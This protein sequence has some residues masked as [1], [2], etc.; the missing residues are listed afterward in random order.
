MTNVHIVP[1]DLE[2]WWKLRS[3]VEVT[4]IVA[5]FLSSYG[6][7]QQGSNA[8][9][10]P[11]IG[12]TIDGSIHPE[13]ISDDQAIRIWLQ[14]VSEPSTA[15]AS[16]LQRMRVKVA[17][18][19]LPPDDNAL[20]LR[21]TTHFADVMLSFRVREQELDR[22][23]TTLGYSQRQKLAADHEQLFIDSKTMISSGLSPDGSRQFA[24][25]LLR[26]KKHMRIGQGP[27]MDQMSHM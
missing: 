26:V 14:A 9:P 18:A 17:A 12:V 1:C 2:G 22:P 24:V 23:D 25:H 15:S 16:D 13:L 5:C 6:K 4:L 20:L 10:P 7:A 19:Q 11:N 27:S 21:C 8:S 3:K